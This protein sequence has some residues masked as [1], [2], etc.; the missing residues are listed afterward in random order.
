MNLGATLALLDDAESA[1]VERFVFASTCSNYGRINGES[2]ANEHF[3]LNPVSLYAE[4]KV[5]GE[6]EVLEAG[7]VRR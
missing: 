6:L 7:V 1:G 4:T 3:P 5:A 2:V